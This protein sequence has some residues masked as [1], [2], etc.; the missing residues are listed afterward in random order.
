MAYQLP[1]VRDAKILGPMHTVRFRQGFRSS[2]VHTLWDPTHAPG[3]D[4]R[5][6]PT[7]ADGKRSATIGADWRGHAT[8]GD[9]DEVTITDVGS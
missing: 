6:V 3:G 7:G 2:T 5:R 1:G 8:A 4:G 9:P